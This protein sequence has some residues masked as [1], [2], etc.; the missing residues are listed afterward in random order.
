MRCPACR[1]PNRESAKF[2][3]EC[4]TPL[5]RACAGCGTELRP[6]AK[7]CDACGNA[8]A[9]AA[10]ALVD[11]EPRDYT[12]KHL[13]SKILQS[14][15]ALEGERKQVTVLFADVKGSLELAEQVDAE[16]WHR[17]LNRF[18]EILTEGVHRF[19]GTVN[20]YTGDGIMA[21]FGAPIAH[22]DHAQRACYAALHLQ[23]ELRAYANELR[24]AR[25][26]S[27]A[28]RIG[29]NSGEVVVG[30]IGDDLRMD[31]TAQGHTVGL[32]QRME[33]LAEPGRTYLTAAT[34]ALARGY[35]ELEDLGPA[36]VAGSSSPVAIFALLGAGSVRTRLDRSR[37][38][39][40]S[41]FVGREAERAELDDALERALEGS[42]QVVGLVAQAGIGKSRLCVE[43]LERCRER[44]IAV[45]QTSGFAHTKNI[46]LMPI[47]QL[48]RDSFGIEERDSDQTARDK[49]AGRVVLGDE[50]LTH[51]LPL[52]FELMGVPDPTRPAGELEPSARE[53]LLVE[54]VQRLTRAR[55]ERQ[56][57]V[58]LIEDLHWL[59][60]A[61]DT[62]IGHLVDAVP[63]TRTV[64]VLNFR[65]EYRAR[66]T[67]ERCYRQLSLEPLGPDDIRELLGDLLGRHP[68]LGE[69][70]ARIESRTAGNPFFV[71][72]LVHGLAE[73]GFLEGS[74]GAYTLA[75][76]IDELRIP[77]GVQ[78]VLAA[79][80]DRLNERDKQLLQA[81]SVIGSSFSRSLLE[82]VV[83]LPAVEI[84]ESLS[85]L[86]ATELIYEEFVY[87]EPEYAFRHPL[88]REVAYGSQ[89]GDRRG[90]IH[91]ATARA[92]EEMD[93]TKLD[94]RAALL[95]HHWEEAGEELT[96][97][98]WHRR[99]AIAAGRARS[100]ESMGH[101]LRVCELL[102]DLPESPE[103]LELGVEARGAILSVP[104][105]LLPRDPDELIAEGRELAEKLGSPKVKA[106]MLAASGM[107]QLRRGATANAVE[108]LR[109]AV[110][111]GGETGDESLGRALPILSI[112]I[113]DAEGPGAALEIVKQI[114]PIHI[115]RPELGR[116]QMGFGAM[117]AIGISFAAIW[118]AQRGQFEQG[119][120]E[121]ERA[122]EMA[123]REGDAATVN[124][125]E[126]NAISFEVEAG[127]RQQA[128]ARA[129][130]WQE[131]EGG[132]G[133][134]RSAQVLAGTGQWA[135][136]E[137]IFA[138]RWQA[139]LQAERRWD[140]YLR[141]RC[142][143]AL[144]E[145][146]RAVSALRD[147]IPEAREVG[148]RMSELRTVLTLAPIL[149]RAGEESPEGEIEQ[150]LD[151]ARILIEETGAVL[152][153]AELHAARAEWMRSLGDEEGWRR[154]LEEAR[155]LY[156]AMG[157]DGHAERLRGELGG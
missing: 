156:A 157:A 76:P 87:P 115:A 109:E 19:E 83:D 88:T 131:L 37:A 75:R 70:P 154:Q 18:F 102:E 53:K 54:I 30:K 29:L 61:S 126:F 56:P 133:G 150:L 79:R 90:R 48:L 101:W 139:A 26:M 34:E 50:S 114:E 111:L 35:F 112:A 95:A 152:F 7:F 135:E 144:G 49:I 117:I 108:L 127:N 10:T 72:E 98:R 4:A 89:L 91:A 14:K 9:E 129:R 143:E 3:E 58:W 96:A 41:K 103:V 113:A 65:P 140:L 5:A 77:A 138:E 68:S 31:Y 66:W 40:F 67:E 142:W 28:V 136:A 151:R 2:C 106:T 128:L 107:V 149:A 92:L 155:D 146:S 93:P 6:S 121:L 81:A 38:R 124:Q 148:A 104:A 73:E 8:V 145:G 24:V 60:E 80:I 78:S 116:T 71:E 147:T 11:R 23:E 42:G 55:S 85:A 12:P 45:Q 105:G 51:A 46:P 100:R 1:H 57:T 119:R 97:A 22:E 25:G 141:A 21:L 125:A 69:L 59:D 13:A 82:M 94:E 153:S 33:Q 27:F 64:L 16:E 63:D 32:A 39:G 134:L 44:G 47:L 137:A 123:R 43:F 62:F 15:S 120:R 74:K 132:I 122:L 86:V 99:A 20:Q 36:Q 130:H 52:L 118:H 110:Q 17:I 84:E